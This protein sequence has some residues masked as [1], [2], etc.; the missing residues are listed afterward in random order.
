MNVFE[1]AQQFIYRNARPIDLVRYQYHFKSGSAQM[2]IDNLAYYQNADGGFGHG[3]EPDA[4]NPHSTPVQTAEAVRLIREIGWTDSEHPVIQG[5]L[6]YLTSGTDFADVWFTNLASNADYPHAEW[7]HTEV[8]VAWDQ[9]NPTASLAGFLVAFSA[10]DSAAFQ[11]GKKI[12]DKCLAEYLCGELVEEMHALTNIVE[13]YEWLAPL[14]LFPLVSLKAKITENIAACVTTDTDSWYS[15]YI[16][17]P[18]QFIDST[19]SSFY[20]SQ[21]AMLQF[22]KQFLLD[23]QLEDGSWPVAWS[24]N[25]YPDAWPIAKNWWQGRNAVSNLLILNL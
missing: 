24:W 23:T 21:K 12:A 22:E 2:V 9:Y 14:K 17:K 15:E 1:K 5:I 16:C 6:A 13:L 20:E 10:A 11:L 3:L 7:W 18:S 19:K 8:D 25:H 4:W